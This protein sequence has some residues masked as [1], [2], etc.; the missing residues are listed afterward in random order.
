MLKPPDD[1]PLLVGYPETLR[2][3]ARRALEAGELEGRLRARYP[4][5]NSITT[6]R[7][8]HEYVSA[9]KSEFLKRAPPLSKIL[10]DDKM[11]LRGLLGLHTYVSRIQGSRL[12]AKNELRV[13]SRF[14][15]LPAEF[16]RM[17]V[18]HELAHLREKEHD[19]AFYQLA[20]HIEPNYHQFELDLRLWLTAEEWAADAPPD[21]EPVDS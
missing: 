12:K 5:P 16:L 21:D 14:K 1:L 18:A 20:C 15:T 4:T 8:L 11:G 19:K 6:D 3:S 2:E 10:F 7:A 13:S 9:L 17:V